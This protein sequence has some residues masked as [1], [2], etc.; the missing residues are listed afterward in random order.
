M[1]SKDNHALSLMKKFCLFED[2]CFPVLKN[3]F[4]EDCYNV[5]IENYKSNYKRYVQRYVAI[6]HIY[7]SLINYSS[8]FD[9]N[10]RLYLSK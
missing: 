8:L 4:G 5:A 3:H 6:S 7:H 9:M 2:D 10:V 1:E